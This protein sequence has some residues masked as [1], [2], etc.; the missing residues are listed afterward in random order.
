M[1]QLLI[2]SNLSLKTFLMIS[3]LKTTLFDDFARIISRISRTPRKMNNSKSAFANGTADFVGTYLTRDKRIWVVASH[4]RQLR[5]LC[6]ANE[7]YIHRQIESYRR[8]RGQPI[9]SK[10]LVGMQYNN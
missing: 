7:F 1:V 5:N 3:Y 10:I 2:E 4:S 8:N 6:S 9:S